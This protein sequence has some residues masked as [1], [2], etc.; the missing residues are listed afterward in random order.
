ML[1]EN[2]FLFLLLFIVS[3]KEWC[4]IMKL[5]FILK[6]SPKTMNF[7]AIFPKVLFWQNVHPNDVIVTF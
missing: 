6:V 3:P 2:P 1:N 4:L 5:V 7:M